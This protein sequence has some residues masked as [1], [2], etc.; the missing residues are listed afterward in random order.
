MI[1]E[2]EE[3]EEQYKKKH[4][5]ID[6][7]VD[8]SDYEGE[9]PD[10]LYSFRFKDNVI[11]PASC[12]LY[13]LPRNMEEASLFIGGEF[14]YV[15]T[16]IRE[17]LLG[18]PGCFKLLH[19]QTNI[20]STEGL[21]GVYIKNTFTFSVRKLISFD[22]LPCLDKDY[23]TYSKRVKLIGVYNLKYV[24]E[25]FHKTYPDY[26]NETSTIEEQIEQVC[27]KDF[28]QQVLDSF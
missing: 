28:S 24:K 13:K 2:L 19:V 4:F 20:K 22:G 9:W 16:D 18:L 21:M 7:K 26:R 8:I 5:D 15:T 14:D 10:W 6:T 11:V 27:S 3:L 17:N 23:K 1:C 12:D 25:L